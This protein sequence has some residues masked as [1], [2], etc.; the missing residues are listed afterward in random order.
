MPEEEDRRRC[1]ID[2]SSCQALGLTQE[3]ALAEELIA[4]GLD[5][6]AAYAAACHILKHYKLADKE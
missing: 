6:G 3:S 4:A 5:G 1:V 2:P